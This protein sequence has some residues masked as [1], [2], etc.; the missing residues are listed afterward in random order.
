MMHGFYF[1]FISYIS[2]SCAGIHKS[3]KTLQYSIRPTVLPQWEAPGNM[4]QLWTT[5]NLQV[6]CDTVVLTWLWVSVGVKHSSA[7]SVMWAA[8]LHF[9]L[10]LGYSVII[11]A[12]RPALGGTVLNLTAMFCCPALLAFYP[13]LLTFYPTLLTFYPAFWVPHGVQQF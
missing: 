11:G 9:T 2:F 7:A 13:A 10:A 4:W 8:L 1:C 6:E 5:F 12:N 3:G